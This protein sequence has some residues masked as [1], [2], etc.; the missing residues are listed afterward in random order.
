VIAL[1]SLAGACG[2]DSS[3]GSP[4]APGSVAPTLTAPRAESPDDGAQLDTLRPTLT[5]TN[6][7][8]TTG[9]ARSYE[10]QVSDT[11]DFTASSA[12]FVS[13]YKVILS[14]TGVPEGTGGK[15]SHTPTADLQPTTVFY[16][17]ARVIQGSATS[18]WSDVRKFKSKLAG[19]LRA[20]ELYDPLIHG[21]TVGERVGATEFV[22]GRGIRLLTN[23]SYVKY[24]LPQTISNGEFSMDV[25]GL[26]PNV[27]GDKSKVF[28]MQEGQGDFVTN[29]WRVDAQYR[30]AQGVPPNCIQWRAMFGDDSHKIEPPTE[31]RYRSVYNLDP[32]RTYHWRGKWSNGFTL[33]VF[34]GPPTG[35]PFYSRYEETSATYRPT[36][37][38]AY[39]GA[40]VGRSG[41]ESA[42]I[43][44]TTYRNVWLGNRPRPTS[45]G[46]ALD[47][48]W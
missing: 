41:N 32:G 31:Y 33:D 6:G 20:G 24:L 35:T 27:P 10:F 3:S 7:T 34:D 14:Q 18:A 21:E 40:P 16:W 8:S 25:E 45:L 47:V 37:H 15:T 48:R 36:P 2:G 12:A 13:T 26:A 30:G 29:L 42:S 11:S 19:Y 1:A 28:G 46:S 9:G 4:T 39:L 43:P 23:T 17:R 44:G 22:P 38:Y 5:V